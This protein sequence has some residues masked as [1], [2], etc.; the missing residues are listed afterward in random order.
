MI[1][2]LKSLVLSLY[3]SFFASRIF[4]RVFM[5]MRLKL[6]NFFPYRI[7]FSQF[8]ED[9]YFLNNEKNQGTYIEIGCNHPTLASNSFRLYLNGWQGLVIDGNS[10]YKNFWRAARPRD[11]FINT[12]ISANTEKD[13]PFYEHYAGFVS[14][15]VKE[16]ADQFDLDSFN[17]THKE[18]R[19]IN[20]VL[21]Q[22]SIDRF[23][24]LFVDI[25]GMD[26]EVLTSLDL[27]KYKPKFIC[28][29]DHNYSQGSSFGVSKINTYLIEKGYL[30]D[31]LLNPSFIYKKSHY[32]EK[33]S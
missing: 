30:L 22:N 26:Y 31:G 19:N 3:F 21:V 24:I 33:E 6:E 27:A 7:S 15:A 13:V 20:E 32:A 5:P 23:D 14:T 17:L 11:I 1:Q 18:T 25:E 29:E 10:R 2:K 9:Q 16:H 4:A 8:G 12:L 28:I